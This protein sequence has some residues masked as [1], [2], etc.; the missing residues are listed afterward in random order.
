[1]SQVA[2]FFYFPAE[3]IPFLGA[4]S[5][6]KKMLFWRSHSDFYNKLIMHTTKTSDYPESGLDIAIA[7]AIFEQEGVFP[8][9]EDPIVKTLRRN[10]EGSYWLIEPKDVPLFEN[11]H[12]TWEIDILEIL[13]KEII[14]ADS[15]VP[16]V[17]LLNQAKEYIL[18]RVKEM[19]Y[20]DAILVS[21]G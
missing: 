15:F 9:D 2:S 13:P 3:K 1:M 18:D 20:G 4:W 11:Y 8:H 19:A 6:R 14:G 16:S 17:K 7:F 5:V 12:R 10:L 21:V